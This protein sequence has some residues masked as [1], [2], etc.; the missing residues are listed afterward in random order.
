MQEP[1][2]LPV[3][4]DEEVDVAEPPPDEATDVRK[5]D[6]PKEGP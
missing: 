1:E 4:D 3:L 6:L 5:E 2:T